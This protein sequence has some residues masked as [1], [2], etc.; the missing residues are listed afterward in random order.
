MSHYQAEMEIRVKVGVGHGFS[1]GS[2]AKTP[3]KLISILADLANEI[4][5]N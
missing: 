1:N 4:I 2:L 3:L 5:A